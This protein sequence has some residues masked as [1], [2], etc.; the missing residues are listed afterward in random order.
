[1]YIHTCTHNLAYEVPQTSN[2][3]RLS[4]PQPGPPPSSASRCP[5]RR[6]RP[7]PVLDF[8]ASKLRLSKVWV[9]SLDVKDAV[10][11]RLELNEGVRVQT[12]DRFL[13]RHSNYKGSGKILRVFSVRSWYAHSA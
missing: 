12:R 11:A 10:G 13:P 3:E 8:M 5:Q 4:E 1:M 9:L 6:A 2:P 7:R